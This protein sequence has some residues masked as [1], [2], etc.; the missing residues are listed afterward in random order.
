MPNSE[1]EAL[2][3]RVVELSIRIANMVYLYYEG[4]KI[5]PDKYNINA[6]DI[7]KCKELYEAISK[8]YNAIKSEIDSWEEKVMKIQGSAKESL[9]VL[10]KDFYKTKDDKGETLE[11]PERKMITILIDDQ[12]KSY[13]TASKV[14]AIQMIK[15][16]DRFGYDIIKNG[17]EIKI[18][19][20]EVRNSKNKALGFEL[21]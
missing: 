19:E 13:V 12:D 14:F 5:N 6:D 11:T 8:D 1:I 2:G 21:I 15:F 9:D 17:L 20:K 4:Y 16:I 3:H 10:I 7:E 18:I